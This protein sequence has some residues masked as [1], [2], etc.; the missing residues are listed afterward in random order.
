MPENKTDHSNTDNSEDCPHNQASPL[1]KRQMSYF[2][3]QRRTSSRL[4][5]TVPYKDISPDV[6]SEEDGNVSLLHS[7]EVC[8]LLS[9][10][11]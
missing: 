6:K 2:D 9:L 5:I 4:P 8:R 3:P 7:Y 10:R 1:L 11:L